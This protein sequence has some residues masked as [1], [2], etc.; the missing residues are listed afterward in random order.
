MPKPDDLKR[1]SQSSASGSAVKKI[2][3]SNTMI[4]DL[5]I[6]MF[7]KVVEILT[8]HEIMRNCTKVCRLW[9]ER[10]ALF[11]LRPKLDKLAK[12]HWVFKMKIQA[13]GW[14]EESDDIDLIL[15]LYDQYQSFSSKI[16]FQW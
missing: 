10:V 3:R 11:I 2:K 6:E 5:P 14:T 12:A 16:Y 4:Q 1:P 7:L 15:S 9:R 8:L 13:E